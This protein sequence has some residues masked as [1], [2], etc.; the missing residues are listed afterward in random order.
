MFPFP[1][2]RHAPAVRRLKSAVAQSPQMGTSGKNWK[3]TEQDRR[4]FH[5]NRLLRGKL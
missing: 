4:L 2:W 5:E 1:N 3:F